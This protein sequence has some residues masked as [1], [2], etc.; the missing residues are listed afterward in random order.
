[1]RVPEENLIGEKEGEGFSQI[2][3]LFNINRVIA[4]SQG[5][6]VAQDGLPSETL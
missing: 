1:V 3:Q 2:I 6:G 5:V 4:A